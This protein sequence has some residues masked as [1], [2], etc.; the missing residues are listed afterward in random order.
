MPI[1][2]L[3]LALAFVVQSIAIGMLRRRLNEIDIESAETTARTVRLVR[4]IAELRS[5]VTGEPP[6]EKR[7]PELNYVVLGPKGSTPDGEAQA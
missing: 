3:A 6:D 4:E 2:T 1:T 7:F 5:L